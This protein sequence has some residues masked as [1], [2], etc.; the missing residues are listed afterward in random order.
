M[1]LHE[2]IAEFVLPKKYLPELEKYILCIFFLNILC[3][4]FSQFLKCSEDSEIPNSTFYVCGLLYMW[5]RTTL[6]KIGGRWQ[7]L[8]FAADVGQL[9]DLECNIL[10]PGVTDVLT[11]A[12]SRVDSYSSLGFFEVYDDVAPSTA[13]SGSASGQGGQGSSMLQSSGD[14]VMRQPDVP[15]AD[16]VSGAGGYEA[17][18]IGDSG[19]VAPA[20]DGDTEADE[21]P[22]EEASDAFSVVVDGVALD[23]SFPLKTIRQA[24]TSLGLARS[25]GKATSLR[26]LKKHLDS[27]LVAQHSAEIQLRA[28]DERVASSP[29]V[30]V[31]P[32]DE[33]RAQRNLTHQPF[34]S[35]CEVC[36]STR[37]R[38]DSHMPRPVPSSGSSVV[39][40]DFGFLKRLGDE[41]SKLT[42]LFICDQHTKLVHVVP[43]PAK[44]GR[45]LSYVTIELCRFV[46]YTQ[47]RA[48]ILRTGS[49]PSTLACWKVFEK[50]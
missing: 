6:V 24:R 30:P 13:A 41:D 42:A 32:S 50:H 37:G 25:G 12:H 46:M 14:V 36:V 15:P 45:Y 43:T 47:H 27:Q 34:A 20:A 39:S 49:E 10:I 16:I 48:V 3:M 33:V 1:L 18:S 21:P 35:W 22:V 40:F 23:S 44:G 2:V 4:F 26:R 31:E 19:A 8:E 5:L 9:S 11:L 7:A 29:A 38:Q 28:D 17:P